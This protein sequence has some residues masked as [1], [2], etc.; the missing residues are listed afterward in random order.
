MFFGFTRSRFGLVFSDIFGILE[1]GGFLGG[2]EGQ[3]GD[4]WKIVGFLFDL[5]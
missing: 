4:D 1:E 5:H 2:G 3:L